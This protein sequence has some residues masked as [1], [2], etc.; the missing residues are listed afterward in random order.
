MCYNV[1][2]LFLFDW[3]LINSNSKKKKKKKVDAGMIMITVGWLNL[4]KKGPDRS[5]K[6]ATTTTPQDHDTVVSILYCI[7]ISMKLN[8]MTAFFQI[9]HRFFL[10]SVVGR[11][12]AGRSNWTTTLQ[13]MK[14]IYTIHRMKV[15][16]CILHRLVCV[17]YA[18]SEALP[19]VQLESE[20]QS[21]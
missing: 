16:L 12:C 20:V 4:V 11:Y 2:F 5:K 3:K 14:E 6:A 21:Q 18:L 10:Y 15:S 9:L 7:R 13:Q 17:P 19:S 1:L 8:I